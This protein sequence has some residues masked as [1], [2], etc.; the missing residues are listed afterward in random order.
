MRFM[1]T[2]TD[3]NRPE[4]SASPQ[5]R[6]AVIT[7]TYPPEVNGVAITIGHM[8]RV[9]RKR[10]HHIQLIRPRQHQLDTPAPEDGYEEVLLAG[11]P[12]PGYPEL[13]VGL[14]AKGA[15]VRLWR[16]R[17]PDIVHIATEGP[18]GWTALT[19]ARKLGIPV[20]TDFHTNFHS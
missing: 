11:M 5:L 8:V 6:V 10:Q 14:P 2:L 16:E 13:R 1:N 3:N 15:L 7:E 19:A 9:L 18:L 12:I 17:R 4:F 20:S